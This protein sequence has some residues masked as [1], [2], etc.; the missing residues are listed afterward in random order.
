MLFGAT[1]F[2]QSAPPSPQAADEGQNVSAVSL[3]AN[4]HRDLKPLVPLVTQK[5]GE[6]YSDTQIQASAAA[7]KQAGNFPQVRVQVEP[8][9]FGT[10]DQFPVGTSLLYRHRGISRRRKVLCL[11]SSSASREPPG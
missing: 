11:Q 6:P 10:Q 4:P 9:V 3:I 1:L 8:D 2:A 7:L 5:A